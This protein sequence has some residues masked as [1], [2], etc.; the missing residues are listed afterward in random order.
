MKKILLGL[1]MLSTLLLGACDTERETPIPDTYGE[2]DDEV[3]VMIETV[4]DEKG[5]TEEGWH[6]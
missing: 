4:A 3:N 6:N 5:L 1:F 2:A